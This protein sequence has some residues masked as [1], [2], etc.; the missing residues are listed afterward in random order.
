[1]FRTEFFT[2]SGVAVG[3]VD[4]P[5]PSVIRYMFLK[6]CN[7]R[8]AFVGS[9]DCLRKRVELSGGFSGFFL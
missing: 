5:C 9:F 1:M 6:T 7:I 4:V 3:Y 8:Q 2:V